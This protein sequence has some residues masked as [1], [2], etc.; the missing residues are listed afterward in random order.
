MVNFV[1]LTGRLGGDAEIKTLPGDKGKVA[2]FNLAVTHSYKTRAGE[3]KNETHWF[4][5]V[6]FQSG[7][8]DKVLA[9]VGTKGRLIHVQGELRA[10]EWDDK[11]GNKRASVEVEITEFDGL[12]PIVEDKKAA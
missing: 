9:K 2:S 12:T 7:L 4:R 5:C 10:R 1:M 11:D 8:I 3:W 6:T